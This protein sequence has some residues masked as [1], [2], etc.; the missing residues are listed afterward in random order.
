MK[1]ITKPPTV[2]I[3][4]MMVKTRTR[5]APILTLDLFSLYI[6]T[7]PTIITIPETTPRPPQT[8]TTVSTPATPVTPGR[9]PIIVEAAAMSSPTIRY[10]TPATRDSAKATVGFATLRRD[11]G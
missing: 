6:N 1:P 4:P 7:D 10:R 5:I 3:A 8:A 11:R 9:E 2:K